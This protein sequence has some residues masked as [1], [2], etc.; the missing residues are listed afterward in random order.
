MLIPVGE[1][2]MGN[3]MISLNDTF[4]WLWELF[5]QGMTF[6]QAVT[7]AQAEFEDPAGQMEAQIAAFVNDCVRYGMLTVECNKED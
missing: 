1:T 7:R 6:R 2:A 3:S 4:A 5:S